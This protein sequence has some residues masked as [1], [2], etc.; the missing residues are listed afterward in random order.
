MT[1]LRIT[2]TVALVFAAVLLVVWGLPMLANTV[3]KRPPVVEDPERARYM[4]ECVHD[5]GLTPAE[6]ERVLQG[7]IPAPDPI[8]PRC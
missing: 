2:L 4:L 1:D 7:G 5:Y 6:C 8:G 3:P